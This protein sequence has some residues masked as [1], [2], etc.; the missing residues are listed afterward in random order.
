MNMQGSIF[1]IKNHIPK[2]NHIF[3]RFFFL[4]IKYTVKIFYPLFFGYKFLLSFFHLVLHSHTV[5]FSPILESLIHFRLPPVFGSGF[6][7]NPDRPKKSGSDP[8]NPDLVPIQKIRIR[9]HDK[10]VQ[11]LQ[12]GSIFKK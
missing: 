6:F 11:K 2:G 10:N 9:F 12:V 1:Y 3:P 4:L 8:E 7:P 5:N